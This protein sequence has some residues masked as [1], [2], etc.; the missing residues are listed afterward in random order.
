MYEEDEIGAWRMMQ[1]LCTLDKM[2]LVFLTGATKLYDTTSVFSPMMAIKLRGTIMFRDVV[3]PYKKFAMKANKRKRQFLQKARYPHQKRSFIPSAVL[4]RE[5]LKSTARPKTTQTIPSNSTANVFYRGTARSRVP[6]AVL[7]RSTGIPY[8]P[9]MDNI[10]PRTS[11][12]S[13]STRSST[14]RT[15]HKPQRPKNTMKS[16]W[17]K[18]ESTVGSQTVLLKIV[19]VKRSAM[20]NQTWRPKGAYLDSVNT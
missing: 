18:K 20:I 15:P 10:R 19:S 4:T 7:S 6:Q 16:I 9:R 17:V 14:T 12:F 2:Y 13:P 11:S 5:G 3:N 8:Y 1:N